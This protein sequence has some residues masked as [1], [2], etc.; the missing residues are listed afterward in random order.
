MVGDL[1]LLVPAILV[2]VTC[3][4]YAHGYLAFRFGDP[5]ARDAGRLTLNPISHL[6]PIGTLMFILVRF[7]WAKPVPVDPRYFRNPRREM[8]WVALA[9]P[10]A[11]MA[12]ALVAGVALSGLVAIGASSTLPASAL[13]L[14]L[15]T[16]QI[17]LALAVFNLIPIPPLDG[18]KML[19][20]IL[21]HQYDPFLDNLE[22][23]GPMILLGLILVSYATDVS[24]FAPLVLGFVELFTRLFTFGIV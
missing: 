21:P 3:H 16:L 1:I 22:R 2:A 11:N 7:G 20:G 10:G 8:L 13:N 6:D 5:T 19:R 24:I 15:I 4:E 12:V 14:L 9:G 23:F 17:N 18:S